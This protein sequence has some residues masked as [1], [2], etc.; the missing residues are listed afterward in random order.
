[1]VSAFHTTGDVGVPQGAKKKTQILLHFSVHIL[2]FCNG[3]QMG[4]Q[5]DSCASLR[6]CF[7][8][9]SPGLCSKPSPP[10]LP[11]TSLEWESKLAGADCLLCCWLQYWWAV[12]RL[13]KGIAAVKCKMEHFPRDLGYR[14]SERRCCQLLRKVTSHFTFSFFSQVISAPTSKSHSVS[15]GS[16]LDFLATSPLVN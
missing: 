9:G 1:M 13:I 3:K 14:D 15:V 8:P 2:P 10:F 7:K 4:W 11:I 12:A 5:R 6:I 16:G